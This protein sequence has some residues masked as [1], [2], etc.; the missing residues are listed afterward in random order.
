[1]FSSDCFPCVTAP[2]L[3][4]PRK[5]ESLDD[6]RK[7]VKGLCGGYVEL[8][9]VPGLWRPEKLSC[10]PSWDV[11]AKLWQKQHQAYYSV[12]VAEDAEALAA[13]CKLG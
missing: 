5:E 7:V 1:M 13:T 11:T 6:S 2:S 4:A 3:S 8:W 10:R 9:L 12:T